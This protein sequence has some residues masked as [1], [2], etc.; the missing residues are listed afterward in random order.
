MPATRCVAC[1][2]QDF[3]V[4]DARKSSTPSLPCSMWY[5]KRKVFTFRIAERP[6]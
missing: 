6:W 4:S 1:P 5:D 3:T 2:F